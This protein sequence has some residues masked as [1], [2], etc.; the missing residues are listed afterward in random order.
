MSAYQQL[1]GQQQQPQ[2]AQNPYVQPP[3]YAHA[4]AGYGAPMP[5]GYQG[6]PGMYVQQQ[7]QQQP[8]YGQQPLPQGYGQ[9]QYQQQ[10]PGAPV[11][12]PPVYAQPPAV[13]YGQQAQPVYGGAPYAPTV[14]TY[15]QQQPQQQQ[16]GQPGQPKRGGKKQ[17]GGKQNGDGIIPDA[18]QG[19]DRVAGG[20][21]DEKFERSPSNC[22][23]MG[24]ALLFI[25]HLIGIISLAVVF[26]R[27]YHDELTGNHES[28]DHSGNNGSDE[29]RLNGNAWGIFGA[30]LGA[31]IVMATLWL[32]LFKHYARTMIW[33]ALL[34]S[35]VLQIA[36]AI[37]FLTVLHSLWAAILCLISAAF[38]LLFVYLVRR[39]IQF[40]ANILTIV[41][42]VLQE[43][44]ATT[45][46]AFFAVL[47]QMVW[48]IVW[49]VAAAGTMHSFRNQEYTETDPN[50]GVVTYHQSSNAAVGC[51]WFFLL[52]SFYWSTQVIRNICHVT[53]AG[54][55]ASWYFL[56][57][58]N[59]PHNPTV[60]AL[61]RASWSSLGSICL[62]SL[63][64]S[65][66]KAMRAMVNMGRRADHPIA[67]CIILCLIDM[68]ERAIAYFNIYAF[69]QIAIYGKP[70]CKA[71]SDTWALLTSSGI[72]A[73]INDDITGAVLFFASLMTG[74]V[75]AATAG[76]LAKTILPVPLWGLWALVGGLLSMGI[77]I[78]A[79]EVVASAVVAL[80]V[81]WAE[82]P[83]AMLNTKP[84]L[85]A[86]MTGAIGQ[87]RIAS[88]PQQG[89]RP[90]RR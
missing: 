44:R 87:H 7:Q 41:V 40:S 13:M 60:G 28:Y 11:Y 30:T 45:A 9:P 75:G 26:Y 72:Q 20:V 50:T 27:M 62:G 19:G 25:A 8:G 80:F 35:P 49:L 68:L 82:D 16:P 12:A 83:Q 59:M 71:A 77:C 56:A 76:I 65:V 79:M 42:Q 2:Y 61:K 52:V 66:V 43:Y 38:N 81:C 90:N 22:R 4:P 17:G 14:V 3:Q 58:N 23:D 84:H 15:P 24:W 1:P 88:P 64:I 37:A 53:T 46:V 36:M 89:S 10:Q 73:L 34:F 18:T 69:T 33:I 32:E 6:Q 21:S 63:I 55:V 67:R 74:L 51:A 54:V 85:Y 29:L 57:P 70:Y 48:V 31:G 47:L 39:R 5:N 78:V 86:A